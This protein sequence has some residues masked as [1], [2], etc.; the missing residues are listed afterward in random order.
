[1]DYQINLTSLAMLLGM[2][3][4]KGVSLMERKVKQVDN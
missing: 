1:M 4:M 2:H 3:K